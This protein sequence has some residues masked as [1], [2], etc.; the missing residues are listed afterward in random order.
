MS[1]I[2]ISL[3][4]THLS[5][6]RFDFFFF[7]GIVSSHLEQFHLSQEAAKCFDDDLDFCP[8]LTAKE[9]CY[10]LVI[11][12]IV[13][14]PPY[15][16]PPLSIEYSYFKHRGGRV[17]R[18]EEKKR[19]GGGERHIGQTK[20]YLPACLFV[21]LFVITLHGMDTMVMSMHALWL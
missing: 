20:A 4:L 21:C 16:V 13:R 1:R 18:R 9:V 10:E 17:P 7:L 6:P 8:S 5:C 11:C 14:F 12:V 2:E 19:K 3:S 15:P